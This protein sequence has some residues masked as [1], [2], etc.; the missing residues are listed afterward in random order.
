MRKITYVTYFI[1]MLSLSL[2][3]AHGRRR[4][5]PR[6]LCRPPTNRSPERHPPTSC[7]RQARTDATGLTHNMSTLKTHTRAHRRGQTKQ[8]TRTP[9]TH[10]TNGPSGES[11]ADNHHSSASPRGSWTPIKGNFQ[12]ILVAHGRGVR[13]PARTTIRKRRCL[14]LRG[15][16]TQ[17]LLTT[18]KVIKDF[19]M[20]PRAVKMSNTSSTGPSHCRHSESLSPSQC[21]CEQSL[22]TARTASC[23]VLCVAIFQQPLLL[24]D[25]SHVYIM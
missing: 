6:R 8:R 2:L 25:H 1:T 15:L 10:Q 5:R 14:Q 17:L 19:L 9:S 20:M 3:V 23:C 12:S 7:S 16:G 22:S 18:N 4:R 13:R 21:C 11:I 24:P